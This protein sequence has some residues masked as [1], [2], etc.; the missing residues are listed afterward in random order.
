MKIKN[1]ATVG[2]IVASFI[3]T[4]SFANPPARLW[5]TDGSPV[6]F[7]DTHLLDSVMTPEDLLGSHAYEGA[8]DWS[9]YV[10]DTVLPVWRD[11]YLSLES[12]WVLVRE[13]GFTDYVDEN[14]EVIL[15]GMSDTKYFS[16]FQN[17]SSH[18]VP[19]SVGNNVVAQGQGI[20]TTIGAL[21]AGEVD[22]T[23]TIEFKDRWGRKRTYYSKSTSIAEMPVI[24]LIN[25]VIRTQPVVLTHINLGAIEDHSAW[26]ND[27]KIQAA[28]LSKWLFKCGLTASCDSKPL[29]EGALSTMS[30]LI[31]WKRQYMKK[32]G[33]MV[34][35]DAGGNTVGQATIS[36]R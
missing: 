31:V 16:E 13:E 15:Q 29:M 17:S 14:T 18:W 5:M 6:D 7:S 12:E 8:L 20:K 30:E 11:S 23:V 25:E 24:E 22:A 32:S 10:G 3:S 9:P 26:V 2:L 1:A 34:V 27:I 36:V 28:G 21:L 4:L 19:A 33:S 35:T